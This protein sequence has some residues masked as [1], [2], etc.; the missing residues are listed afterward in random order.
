MGRHHE[1]EVDSSVE[2]DLMDRIDDFVELLKEIRKDNLLWERNKH[3]I[4]EIVKEDA[5]IV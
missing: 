5:I 2:L 4:L 3:E 1:K